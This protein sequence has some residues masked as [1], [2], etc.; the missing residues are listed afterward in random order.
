MNEIK[1]T[2]GE[3]TPASL[4][5]VI[6]RGVLCLCGLLLMAFSARAISPAWNRDGDF[7]LPPA[8]DID[9]N[10]TERCLS[11]APWGAESWGLEAGS[12]N[13]ANNTLSGSRFAQFGENLYLYG[14]QE[15][16]SDDP[17]LGLVRAIQGNVW[18]DRT[19]CEEPIPWHVPDPLPLTDDVQIA[20]DYRLD[21]A[22]LLTSDASWLM[23]ALNVWVSSPD[24]PP[25]DDGRG[26]KPLVLD[27]VL[28]HDCNAP[29]CQ[30]E[31]FEDDPAFHY[32]TLVSDNR[33]RIG[34]PLEWRAS[35]LPYVQAALLTEYICREGTC[36]GIPPEVAANPDAL[37][38]HQLEFVIEMRNAEG[39]ALIDNFHLFVSANAAQAEGEAS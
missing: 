14:K 27:L 19:L 20:L 39:A 3:T 35:L 28:Y 37:R 31:H 1:R 16:P 13:G 5:V 38:L 6:I 2:Q 32:Q 30:L 25:G 26:H 24:F 33:L 9:Q 21:T 15:T 7:A 18:Q 34:T 11:L 12:F 4:P 29:G 10:Y 17:A 23:I 22:A 36:T 8:P